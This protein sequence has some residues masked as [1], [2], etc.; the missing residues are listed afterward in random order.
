MKWIT[1]YIITQNQN[2]LISFIYG[3]AT[4]TKTMS[5]NEIENTNTMTA[6][7]ARVSVNT[8][9]YNTFHINQKQLACK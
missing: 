1:R 7:A 9:T 2:D 3:K 6:N 5:M 4:K 8:N